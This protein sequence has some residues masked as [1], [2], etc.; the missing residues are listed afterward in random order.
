MTSIEYVQEVE[1]I[2]YD[3]EIVD[4]ILDY[5]FD[6]YF[7]EYDHNNTN[8]ESDIY[9]ELYEF[10]RYKL[11][12]LYDDDSNTAF[13]IYDNIF[14]VIEYLDLMSVK[15]SERKLLVEEI[16]SY[17]KIM[18]TMILYIFKEFIQSHNFDKERFDFV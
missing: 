4:V 6:F 12:D 16:N 13:D 11:H 9:E 1:Q 5:I 14:Y 15:Y 8:D 7:S 2:F 18:D 3:I 10:I 17:E